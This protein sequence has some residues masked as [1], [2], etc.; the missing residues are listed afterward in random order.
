MVHGVGETIVQGLVNTLA[1]V[2]HPILFTV[3]AATV[4][5][6][7]LVIYTVRRQYWFAKEFEKRVIKYLDKRD[8][9]QKDSF[10]VVGKRLLERTYYEVFEVRSIM[11]RRNLDYVTSP[12]DRL[13]AIQHGCARFVKDTLKEIRFLKHNGETPRFLD[14][15]K[16]VIGGNPCF[17]R[18]FGW[19][20][21][22]PLNELLNILPGLFIIAGVFGTFLGVMEGL[23]ELGNLDIKDSEASKIVMDTFLLKISFAIANS[24][25]GI[26][27][28]VLLS[29]MYALSQV[30]KQFVKIV[31][32]YDRNLSRLWEASETNVVPLNLAAFDE[33]KDPLEALAQMAVDKEFASGRWS[34]NSENQEGE[35]TKKAS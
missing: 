7:G 35:V 29:V 24:I 25:L 15:S 11:Q 14:I 12:I 5:L 9:A 33:H 23:P 31:D 21:L 1:D 22:G 27:F 6:K 2:L 20:P 32:Q 8:P 18:L 34:K 30:E 16:T 17:S 28:S 10:Y 4:V 3:F 13:F 26:F 19:I